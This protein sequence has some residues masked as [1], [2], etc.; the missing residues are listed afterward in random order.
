MHKHRLIVFLCIVTLLV[1]C[2]SGSSSDDGSQ[3]GDDDTQTFVWT[4]PV[5]PD[6]ESSF[7]NLE[8]SDSTSKSITPKWVAVTD[9]DTG[10]KTITA[11][12]LK[13]AYRYIALI[14]DSVILDLGQ[15]GIYGR[16]KSDAWSSTAISEYRNA[17]TKLPGF[18]TSHYPD[19]A[20]TDVS[21]LEFDVYLDES[22]PIKKSTV[23][24]NAFVIYDGTNATPSDVTDDTLA[25]F[26]L[27]DA[28]FSVDVKAVPS[29]GVPYT[30]VAYELVYYEAKIN[31]Y[32]SI[33]LYYND[34]K[35]CKAGDFMVDLEGD[36][37]DAGWQ[38]AYLKHG[39]GPDSYDGSSIP[40]IVD[41]DN[42]SQVGYDQVN[43]NG[44][45]R[46][47]VGTYTYNGHAVPTFLVDGDNTW[48]SSFVPNEDKRPYSS[49]ACIYWMAN[50]ELF[51]GSDAA[52]PYLY[53]HLGLDSNPGGFG[54]YNSSTPSLST[55]LGTNITTSS[56]ANLV[57][58]ESDDHLGTA[59]MSSIIYSASRLDVTTRTRMTDFFGV[60]AYDSGL[61]SHIYDDT[62]M[63]RQIGYSSGSIA[64]TE[65]YPTMLDL[66]MGRMAVV[67]ARYGSDGPAPYEY[68]PP[69]A[70]SADFLKE[71]IV[72]V[73]VKLQIKVAI[74][75][76]E[77]CVG[78]PWGG[79]TAIAT[80][81]FAK[82]FLSFAPKVGDSA[83]GGWGLDPNE[84]VPAQRGFYGHG[85][86]EHSL[87]TN[88][89]F[90]LESFDLGVQNV[91]YK[92]VYS[93]APKMSPDPA[94]AP[95]SESLM[96]SL[97]AQDLAPGAGASM[98]YTTDGSNPTT[99][100]TKYT[101]PFSIGT[102]D[103]VV[104]A[105]TM[106]DAKKFI[107]KI[108]EG[109]YVFA[110]T[111]ANDVGV[112]VNNLGSSTAGKKAFV[113]L[114]KEQALNLD[115]ALN[116][117]MSSTVTVDTNSLSATIHGVPNGTFYAI[118][119]IDMDAS[120]T[121]SQG[122]LLYPNAVSNRVVTLQ[123]V[124]VPGSAIIINGSSSYSVPAKSMVRGF[125]LSW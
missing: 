52:N 65:L 9:T 63:V 1:S 122:D 8:L 11:D 109:Q 103:T 57:Y 61:V 106:E 12:G 36:S 95:F 64:V 99:S 112:T 38:W 89:Y 62:D 78:R 50:N 83:Y 114:F 87:E 88:L 123:M 26:D 81:D 37:P 117:V 29:V 76:G 15:K 74:Y 34:Y 22:T 67:G 33:R 32:G 51:N 45:M 2:D 104:K 110:K 77:D 86:D 58:Y 31:G 121:L 46:D 98:Y 101:A 118:A 100:S 73:A 66:S 41:K 70:S 107:S 21:M 14:P 18:N 96:I 49:Q 48:M 27:K 54:S 17:M 56:K 19:A 40:T 4:K 10:R 43:D 23:Q 55:A 105:I 90:N 92:D 3:G 85:S 69:S 20:V 35:S 25:I 59:D 119:I 116:P 111:T 84:P 6:G 28:T 7:Q 24:G 42:V 68:N 80:D 75:N 72:E 79:G 102:T 113:A 39:D 94:D 30:G 125:A 91:R 115:N 53:P 44:T 97:T 124:S 108:S 16:K 13:V 60:Y 71:S 47:Y 5:P 82:R 93:I 120:N